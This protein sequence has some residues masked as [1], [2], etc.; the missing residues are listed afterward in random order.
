MEK[1]KS[2]TEAKLKKDLA[3]KKARIFNFAVSLFPEITLNNLVIQC[4]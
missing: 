1:L 4:H 2:K 3:Y